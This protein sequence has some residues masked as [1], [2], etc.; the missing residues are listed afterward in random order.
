[1]NIEQILTLSPWIEVLIKNLYWKLS[2]VNKI[3][4]RKARKNTK[5]NKEK[6]IEAES[7]EINDLKSGLKLLEVDPNG[8][9]IIHSTQSE[10]SRTGL[11]AQDICKLLKETLVPN[12]TLAMPAIPL[13]AEE[14][15]GIERMSDDICRKKITYDV[16]KTR[17]WTGAL[18]RALMSMPESIRSRHPINSM[19]ALGR[20]ADEMMK[21]NINGE[22][23]TAC[24]PNS[25]WKYC[26]DLNA[27]IVCIGVDTS[28]SLTM[29]HVAEDSFEEAWPVKNWYRER[30]FSI[31]DEGF[32]CDITVKE[33]R[34]KWA[35]YYAE[36]TLQ[37]DLL[38][39]GIIKKLNIKGLKIE[40]CKAQDLLNYLNSRKKESY[41][42]YIPP[43]IK[44]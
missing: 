17:T 20:H 7:I 13:F 22:K 32:N 19:V 15:S 8:I 25:S 36:R 43:W 34:P 24:G 1:M 33:R 35:I 41:P 16:K 5:K 30:N 27:T 10:L 42:Y 23:P 11:N 28:H 26:A 44:K 12:G 39:N 6:K 14:P 9:V 18:P 4:S 40:I 31:K 29:I 3:L 2:V 37:K 21:D 38:K